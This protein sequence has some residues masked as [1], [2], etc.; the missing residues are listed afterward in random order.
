MITYTNAIRN[1]VDA[2]DLNAI[3]LNDAIDAIDVN[4]IF[5]ILL[6]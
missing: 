6:L 3:D 1:D 5:I 2:I 4:D